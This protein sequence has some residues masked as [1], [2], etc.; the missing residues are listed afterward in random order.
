MTERIDPCA[1]VAAVKRLIPVIIML[2]ALLGCVTIDTATR[3]ETRLK[4]EVP[5]GL[6]RTLAVRIDG[7]AP[8]TQAGLIQALERE[9]VS[10]DLFDRVVQL[11]REEA[12]AR[13][14][15]LS[16]LWVTLLGES[17]ESVL[18]VWNFADAF[19]AR[20]EIQIEL[21]DEQGQLILQGHVSGIG[22]DDVSDDDFVDAD[23]QEDVRRAA[24]RDAATKV[25]RAL[26]RAA[27][28]R[29]TKAMQNLYELRLSPGVG[30]VDVAV[31]GFDD[32]A[33]AR[34]RRGGL[35]RQHMI[36]ALSKLGPEIS[37]FDDKRVQRALEREAP[38]SLHGISSFELD[39][40][41]QQL[42]GPRYFVVGRVALLGG[43]VTAEVRLLD[44]RG[45]ELQAKQAVA[46]GL[47][48]IPVVAVKLTRRLSEGLKEL[49]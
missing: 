40:I 38:A 34:R 10:Q 42:P 46:E 2:P 6:G 4:G 13:A 48:A 5:S 21:R 43:R 31:L 37:V 11:D 14:T 19:V 8:E 15:G 7:G 28:A 3:D 30:P 9:F 33:A 35:L 45:E 12:T 1:N 39:R 18:D 20:Y 32:E 41:A 17:S 26:R 25:S 24:Q 29:A 47:G 22:A 49:E 27:N 44:A 36:Q 16:S 23:K